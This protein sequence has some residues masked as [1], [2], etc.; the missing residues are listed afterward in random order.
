MDGS[1]NVKHKTEFLI[2]GAGAAGCSLGYLLKKAGAEVLVLE[3][4][5]EATRAKLCA[6]I[7]EAQAEQAFTSVFGMS[8]DEAGLAPMNL[9]YFNLRCGTHELPR[10]TKERSASGRESVADSKPNGLRSSPDGYFKKSGKLLAKIILNQA[11][12]YD[13]NKNGTFRTLPRKWLDDFIRDRY[14]SLGGKLLDCTVIRSVNEAAGVAQCI[15]LRTKDLFE[16]QFGN[17]IGADGACSAVRRL[18]SGIGPEA[19]LALETAVPLA[20]QGMIM[21]L[22]P[23][24]LGYNWYIPRG[25][26]AT[27]GCYYMDLDYGPEAGAVCRQR[28]AAFCE[29]FGMALPERVPGALIP[30]GDQVMLQPGK[31]TFLV[32]DAAGLI[33]MFTGGGIHYALLSAQALAGSFTGGPFYAEAMKPHLAFINKNTENVKRY[34]NILHLVG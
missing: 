31:R 13:L 19:S 25:N 27:V 32:G 21:Q 26:D 18:V 3:R 20:G 1:Q 4:Q 11:V 15:D 22:I 16:V 30:R 7:L 33:D 12:G 34:Y 6:G 28:L 5:D 2:V 10:A 23:G 14:L 8:V 29:E 24:A 9:E 17:L